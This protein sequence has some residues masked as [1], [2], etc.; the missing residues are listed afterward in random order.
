LLC[1]LDEV[2]ENLESPLE[3]E[4]LKKYTEAIEFKVS[5]ELFKEIK[6]MALNNNTDLI[7]LVLKV[8]EVLKKNLDR[9]EITNEE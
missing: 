1:S 3:K 2:D 4:A 5:E 6:L 7:K 9:L 8:R